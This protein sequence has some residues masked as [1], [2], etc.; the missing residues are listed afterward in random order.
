MKTLLRLALLCLLSAVAVS[1]SLADPP[2]EKQEPPVRLKKKARPPEPPGEDKKPEKQPEK[3]PEPPETRKAEPPRKEDE[4]KEEV[5]PGMA[6]LEE[7]AKEAAARIA[8]NMK[9]SED[10]LAQK[11]PGD[12]TQQIQ[13]DIL[14]DLDS[15]IE[16][17]KRQQQ[18]QQQ[19]SSSSQTQ[20]QKQRQQARQQRQQRNRQVRNQNR[21][22][23]QPK[24]DQQQA[25]NPL[26]GDKGGKEEKDNLADLYKDVWGHLPETLRM[27]MDQ[28]AR[29]RF[30]PRYS[31]LLKQ[32][33]TTIAEKS[34]R[35]PAGQ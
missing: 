35:K 33:Y 5:D 25:K 15:L 16:R 30:M 6:Q 29:E 32:Y 26:G 10:R 11:D 1:W 18:Q 3:K 22:D 8:K 13:Q 4:P 7:K 24:E 34:R 19:Q 31:E 27:E 14:K 17:S 2:S 28:Y 9:A 23:Q 12:A 21:P 20:E